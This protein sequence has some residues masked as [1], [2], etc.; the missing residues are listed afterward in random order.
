MALENVYR[1]NVSTY[2]SNKICIKPIQFEH[3]DK[4]I[5]ICHIYSC[6][7]TIYQPIFNVRLSQNLKLKSIIK[8]GKRLKLN[9]INKI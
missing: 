4:Y 9:C 6:I 2:S 5:K 8:A 3:V 1:F 7:S